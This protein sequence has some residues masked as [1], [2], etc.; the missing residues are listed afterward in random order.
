MFGDMFANLRV[1]F[2]AK[3]QK[4]YQIVFETFI[5]YNLFCNFTQ[6]GTMHNKSSNLEAA[7]LMQQNIGQT[8][9]GR[10]KTG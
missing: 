5:I 2:F 10:K 1:S 9:I 4:K 3:Y 6:I 7:F 8:E